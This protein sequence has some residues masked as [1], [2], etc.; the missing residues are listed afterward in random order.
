MIYYNI[1]MFSKIIPKIKELYFLPVV[2]MVPIKV[3]NE[4]Y[5]EYIKN[6]DKSL[7]LNTVGCIM[8]AWMGVMTGTFL[9][10]TWPISLPIFI[11]RSIDN[12]SKDNSKDNRKD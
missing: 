12:N 3:S 6:K 5:E 11:A 10:I 2:F 9:G 7:T 8:G 1:E 4:V